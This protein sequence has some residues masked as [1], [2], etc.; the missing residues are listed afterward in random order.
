MSAH[1]FGPAD[2]VAAR[3]RLSAQAKGPSRTIQRGIYLREHA[4]GRWS[5]AIF[6]WRHGTWSKPQIVSEPTTYR[7]AR[8]AAVGAWRS[9][10]LP[11]FY[12]RAGRKGAYCFRPGISEPAV[13]ENACLANRAGGA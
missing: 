5:V 12:S 11:F 3:R 13:G 4:D 9:T 1:V 2:W 6:V 10:S 7:A 8:E